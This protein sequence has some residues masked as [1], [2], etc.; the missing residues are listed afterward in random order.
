MSIDAQTS[1]RSRGESP[2]RRRDWFQRRWSILA[3][4]ATLA[5]VLAVVGWA[6]LTDSD[7]EEAADR[8]GEAWAAEDYDAMYGMLDP[9]SREQLDEEE[10]ADAYLD[11]AGTATATELEIEGAS[12]EDGG[13]VLPVST[14]TEVFGT[15]AG[16]VRLP[17]TGAGEVEWAPHLVFPGLAEGEELSRKT[18]APERAPLLAADGTVLAEGDTGE[19]TTEL[20]ADATAV[21][22]TIIPAYLSNVDAIAAK[23]KG[24]EANPLGGQMGYAFAEY[25]WLEA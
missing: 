14:A 9:A 6:L 18:T 13:A 21:A 2:R 24:L 23:L 19:R 5:V 3:P 7:A 25:V 1:M 4:A 10:F 8:F 11:T 15:I 17:L 16:D 22:G 20:A 12:E